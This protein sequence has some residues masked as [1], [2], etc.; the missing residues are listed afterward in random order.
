MQHAQLAQYWAGR[1]G[2]MEGQGHLT[3]A[4]G[5]LV[6][7]TRM[8]CSAAARSTEATR[9]YRGLYNAVKQTLNRVSHRGGFE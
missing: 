4:A 6:L 7:C 2:T 9:H 3:G 8:L 5:R 1:A